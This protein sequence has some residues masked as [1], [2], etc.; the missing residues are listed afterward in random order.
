MLKKYCHDNNDIAILSPC[1]A[2]KTEFNDTGLAKYNVTFSELKKYIESGALGEIVSMRA[3]FTCWYPEIEG[4]WRQDK[5]RS[6]GGAL[7]DMGVVRII[8]LS[9]R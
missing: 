8:Q 4:N 1:I 2:K 6:G 9:C 5:K 3:Q 7:M